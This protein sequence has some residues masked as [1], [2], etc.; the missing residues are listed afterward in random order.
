MTIVFPVLLRFSVV[1]KSPVSILTA[2]WDDNMDCTFHPGNHL[3]YKVTPTRRNGKLSSGLTVVRNKWL[4]SPAVVYVGIHS[5]LPVH[6][7]V[8]L[9]W[10]PYT[11]VSP[12][13]ALVTLFCYKHT[14]KP[15]FGCDTAAADLWP[16][17]QGTRC[18]MIQCWPKQHDRLFTDC[19]LAS[20]TA[21]SSHWE[22]PMNEISCISHL[23]NGWKHFHY[24]FWGFSII[25]VGPIRITA[26]GNTS[27]RR[28]RGE[29]KPGRAS[30]PRRT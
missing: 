1:W 13:A 28:M 18:W 3:Q 23:S 20:E 4:N 19:E 5:C 12:S 30:E 14:H 22:Q 17:I 9:A 2:F 11:V 25:L 6:N 15:W 27:S 26:N 10:V 29:A 7:H 21:T 16:K 24:V 8:S